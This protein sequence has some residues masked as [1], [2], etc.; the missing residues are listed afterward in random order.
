MKISFTSV[1]V[2]CLKEKI[3]LKGNQ[4]EGDVGCYTGVI[5]LMI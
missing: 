5:F 4:R 1:Q 2:Q 3:L